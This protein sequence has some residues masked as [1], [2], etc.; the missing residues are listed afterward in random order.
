MNNDAPVLTKEKR[1]YSLLGLQTKGPLLEAN[2]QQITNESQPPSTVQ[3]VLEVNY[4]IESAQDSRIKEKLDLEKKYFSRFKP[5]MAEILT[6]FLRFI[7]R[8]VGKGQVIFNVKKGVIRTD[9]PS[10]LFISIKDP[11]IKYINHGAS[12]TDKAKYKRIV[13]ELTGL[14]EAAALEG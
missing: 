7:A 8:K 12:L 6:K 5:N 1:P 9:K 13:E 2:V 11:F 10:R 4:F 3:N 14:L